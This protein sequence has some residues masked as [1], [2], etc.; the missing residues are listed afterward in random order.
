VDVDMNA[1]LAELRRLSQ[2][3]LSEYEKLM[4]SYPH[5]TKMA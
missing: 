4:T 2:E 3:V 1:T 5:P